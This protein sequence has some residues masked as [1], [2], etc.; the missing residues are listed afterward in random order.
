MV[1]DATTASC[2]VVKQRGDAARGAEPGLRGSALPPMW[3][4]GE[5]GSTAGLAAALWV[6][7]QRVGLSCACSAALGG[8]ICVNKSV[9]ICVFCSKAGG[10]NKAVGMEGTV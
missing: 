6:K 9:F 4:K 3:G 8:V 5:A 1:Q 7:E 2:A 10:K